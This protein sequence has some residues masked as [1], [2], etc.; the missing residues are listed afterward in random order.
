MY[1]IRIQRSSS[2]PHALKIRPLACMVRLTMSPDKNLALLLNCARKQGKNLR[3]ISVGAG[4]S[5]RLPHLLISQVL[6]R[7]SSTVLFSD[8]PSIAEKFEESA[9]Y[10]DG[11]SVLTEN[12]PSTIPPTSKLHSDSLFRSN[13]HQ[14]NV[15]E[16]DKLCRGIS[17]ELNNF[18][19]RRSYGTYQPYCSFAASSSQ[20]IH[21]MVRQLGSWNSLFDI[22][23]MEQVP[24]LRYASY[25]QFP[26]PLHSF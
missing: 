8:A 19:Q 10:M 4:S 11:L 25:N 15:L 20:R 16:K 22:S 17:T 26:R 2:K 7:A 3:Q 14:E 5:M 12:V 24:T 18:G 1:L 13:I 9:Y 21:V 6:L 23:F